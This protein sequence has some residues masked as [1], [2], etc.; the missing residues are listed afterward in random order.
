MFPTEEKIMKYLQPATY[1]VGSGKYVPVVYI[2]QPV[3]ARLDEFC[4]VDR[5]DTHNDAMLVASKMR[6]QLVS[7]MRHV[8]WE[9]LKVSDNNGLL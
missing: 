4:P 5:Y 7:L 8:L 3:I 2:G 9:E 6:D 1:E